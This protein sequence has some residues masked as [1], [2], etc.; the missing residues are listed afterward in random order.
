MAWSGFF[1]KL[2][3]LLLSRNR[4]QTEKGLKILI[5][6]AQTST[7]ENVGLGVPFPRQWILTPGD[8]IPAC[9]RDQVI[10]KEHARVGLEVSYP[11]SFISFFNEI[12]GFER[13][14]EAILEEIHV[15][16]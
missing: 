16:S 1:V 10:E 6:K 3:G 4:S 5:V 13:Q 11:P 12:E 15:A 9:N 14:A 2:T 7:E 8:I